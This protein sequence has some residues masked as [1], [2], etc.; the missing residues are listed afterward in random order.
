VDENPKRWH[1]LDLVALD[2]EGTGAQ[3][4]EDE[5]ILEVAAIPIHAG[6]PLIDLAYCTLINPHRRVPRRPWISPGLDDHLLSQAPTLSHVEPHLTSKLNGRYVVGH[7]ILVDWRLLHRRFPDIHVAGLIDTMKLLR[8]HG[9][10]RRGLSDALESFGL[11][12]KVNQTA[13]ASQPHRA[14]WDATGAALLLNLLAER[15]ALTADGLI[16]I[17]GI[18]AH[19]NTE[20]EAQATLF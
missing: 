10:I 18:P 5:A 3:D 20:A 11:T 7:N 9:A 2:L 8:H 12:G 4:R 6:Q 14:L 13:P 1:E 17:A 19:V 15:S 16:A